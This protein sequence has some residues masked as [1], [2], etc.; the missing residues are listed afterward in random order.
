MAVAA[1]P[2]SPSVIVARAGSSVAFGQRVPVRLW[3]RVP[4]RIRGAENSG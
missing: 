3:A 2:V 1:V 4:R